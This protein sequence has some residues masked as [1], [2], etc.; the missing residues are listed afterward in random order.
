[1]ARGEVNGFRASRRAC[2][3][4]LD[5]TLVSEPALAIELHDL[6]IDE[7]HLDIDLPF[8]LQWAFAILVNVFA[9][10]VLGALVGFLLSSIL[11]SLAEAFFPSD[12]GSS[13]PAPE[14]RPLP[15]LP[16]G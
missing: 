4:G 13:L 7:P 8:W 6:Q 16:R 5:P 2:A 15:S 14:A 9:G 3:F 1:V 11:A 12:L 10:T